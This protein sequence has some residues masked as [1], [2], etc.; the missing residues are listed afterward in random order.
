MKITN[1]T[2]GLLWMS[3]IILYTSYSVYRSFMLDDGII[4]DLIIG[5]I[6]ILPSLLF[7]FVKEFKKNVFWINIVYLI[8]VI[9]GLANVFLTNDPLK[10]WFIMILLVFPISF[11]VSMILLILRKDK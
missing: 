6:L 11:I 8:M 1:K 2:L 3:I 9:W 10:G 5:L 7:T 4:K